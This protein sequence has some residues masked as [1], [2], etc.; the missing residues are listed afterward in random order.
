[1]SG[2]NE[3]RDEALR[4]AKDHG[5]TGASVGE[6]IALMHSE[7]S[8]ALEDHRDGLAANEMTYSGS[9]PCG[10]PSEMADVII[11]VLHF[12]GKHH[13]DIEKAVREKMAYNESRPFK[14]GGRTL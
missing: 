1:M 4:I 11:R 7:L 14:H 2:L 3:L 10:I 9:K 8:E 6:D 12:C 5:F 13:I